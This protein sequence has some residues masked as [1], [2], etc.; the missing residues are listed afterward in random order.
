MAYVLEIVNKWK[1][2]AHKQ[3]AYY[4]ASLHFISP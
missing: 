2:I 4:F 1:Q 3:D